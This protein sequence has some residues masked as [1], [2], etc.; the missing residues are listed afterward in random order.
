MVTTVFRSFPI[1]VMCSVLD[2]GLTII[3]VEK[4]SK[5]VVLNIAVGS[6]SSSDILAGSAHALEHMV[7][8]DDVNME[9]REVTLAGCYVNGETHQTHTLYSVSGSVQQYEKMFSALATCVSRPR[10]EKFFFKRELPSVLNEFLAD[11]WEVAQDIWRASKL[12]PKHSN[13]MRLPL[14]KSSDLRK[15]RLSNLKHFYDKHYFL[16]NMVIV[17]SGMV[18][19]TVLVDAAKSSMLMKMPS[20]HRPEIHPLA[21]TASRDIFSNYKVMYPSVQLYLPVPWREDE[22]MLSE[23]A[24]D[25]FEADSYG[26]IYKRLCLD[27]GLLYGIETAHSGFPECWSSITASTAERKLP[28]IELAMYEEIFNLMNAPIPVD[29]WTRVYNTWLHMLDTWEERTNEEFV[30]YFVSRWFTQDLNDRWYDIA[31]KN[32]T[33]KRVQSLLRHMWKPERITRFRFTK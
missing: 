1:P 28:T 20:G 11:D 30:E 4:K 21:F 32:V 6:G 18:S 23:M 14:G 31:I 13:M 2:N 19:H 24:I 15:I 8:S 5:E 10:F 7:I 16:K 26:T 12:Y 27:E 25:L 17:A 33:P 9:R 22:R 29:A 3:T